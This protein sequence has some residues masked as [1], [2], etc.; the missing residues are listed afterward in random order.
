MYLTQAGFYWLKLMGYYSSGWS[1]VL[2]GLCESAVIA[3]AY[4]AKQIM[5]YIYIDLLIFY[6]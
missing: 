3:W 2:I 1:L 6:I 5:T 4:S